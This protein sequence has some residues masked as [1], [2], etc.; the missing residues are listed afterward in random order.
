M[1]LSHSHTARFARVLRAAPALAA[2]LCALAGLTGAAPARA[3]PQ[4]ASIMMDDDQL[5]YRNDATREATLKVMQALG[6][7]YVRVT[8][9]WSN[10]ALG[11]KQ[12][13]HKHHIAFRPANPAAYP[14]ANWNR[15]DA[16]VRSVQARGMQVYFDVTGPG[17]DYSHK[18]APRSLRRDVAS[19]WMPD[20][21]QFYSFVAAV[22][23]RYSGT[24]RAH[25]QV[26]PRVSFWSLWNEPNQGGW[27]TPQWYKGIPYSPVIY[28]KLWLYGRQA[29]TL[30]GHGRDRILLG[31]TSPLYVSRHTLTSEIAPKLFIRELMCADPAGRPY[32]GAA[33][34]KRDC[35]VFARF[36]GGFA[37]TGF[38]HHPY[39]KFAAPTQR[40]PNPDAI[41]VANIGE[42]P[43]LLDQL[44]AS[45]HHVAAGLSVLSTENGYETNPPDP[46]SGIPLARQADWINQA[47]FLLYSNP[48]VFGNTQFLLRD[49]APLRQ[50]PRGSRKYWSTYQSGLEFANGSPKPSQAAYAFPFMVNPGPKDAAGNPQLYV[51]GQLRFLAHSPLGARPQVVQVEYHP[52][53]APAGAFVPVGAPIAVTDT[54]RHFLT[55]F[56]PVPGAGQLRLHWAGGGGNVYSR[57]IAVP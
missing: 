24:Y 7:D 17:P 38:A 53:N 5:V 28:R 9:L 43:A 20:A 41:T 40:D 14:A 45:T 34:A 11:I 13:D 54:A 56:I 4:Q 49:A 51:W 19:T 36:G 26:I 23:K 10:V 46:F 47:D 1:T 48:R 55:T 57:S 29:L 16:L 18:R 37:T 52:G 21:Q 39:T 2:A 35:G 30:T 31:E 25:G 44:A 12:Y 6:V 33:A 3:N 32:T 22:G 8:V 42:L 27:I 15:Y 50:Y